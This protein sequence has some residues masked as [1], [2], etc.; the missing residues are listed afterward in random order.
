[1]NEENRGY[2]WGV[3]LLV[4]NE[5]FKTHIEHPAHIT[6]MC[7]MTET[8]AMELYKTIGEFVGLKY[9]AECNY[10]CHLFCDKSYSNDDPFKYSSGFNCMLN[11]WNIFRR[12]CENYLKYNPSFGS[13]SVNPHLTYNYSKDINGVKYMNLEHSTYLSCRLVIADIRNMSPSLWN[14]T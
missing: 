13:F 14:S 11:E 10:K 6:I 9:I 7:N 3:W 12:I 2:G 4:E 8:D 5:W 1:M